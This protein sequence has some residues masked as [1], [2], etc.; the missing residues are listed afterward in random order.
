MKYASNTKMDRNL[1]IVKLRQADTDL[2]LKDIAI[3][4]HISK[5]RVCAILKRYNSQRENKEKTDAK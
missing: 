5:T 1:A 3:I 2:S 4:F